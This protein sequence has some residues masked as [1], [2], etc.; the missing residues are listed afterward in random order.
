[1]VDLEMVAYKSELELS[2][3]Q[4]L[5]EDKTKLTWNPEKEQKQTSLLVSSA[6]PTSEIDR[7]HLAAF[8]TF[9]SV[10]KQTEN[11]VLVSHVNRS[12]IGGAD[13]RL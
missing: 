9:M 11:L 3:L 7:H 6:R 12:T 5:K 2:C 4:G 1:M 10:W 13:E 8:Q